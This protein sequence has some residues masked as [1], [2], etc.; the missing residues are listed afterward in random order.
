MF[1]NRI[2]LPIQL[3][4]PQFPE[5]R[6]SFRKANGTSKTMSVTIR[7]TYQLETDWFPENWHQRLKIALAH[8]EV[9]IEGEKY[10]GDISQDG[11]YNIEWQDTPLH[12][13]T[14]KGAVLVQVTPFNATNSNCQS[15]DEATQLSLED[16]T[17]TGIYGA[18][19]EDTDYTWPLADNDNI[20]CYPAVFS[21]TYF[22]SDYLDSASINA[23]TGELSFHTRTGLTSANGII[24]ATYRVTCPNGGYDEA[25]VY[26]DFSGSVEGCLAPTD[27]AVLDTGTDS[28]SFDW[29]DPDPAPDSYEWELYEGT[30]PVG[31]PVATGSGAGSASGT[32]GSLTPNTQY[33]F[34]VRSVCDATTSNWI[35]ITAMTLAEDVGCGQYRLTYTPPELSGFAS[36]NYINCVPESAVAFVPPNGSTLIC[37]LENSPGDPVSIETGSPHISITYL[38]P[39]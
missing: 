35:S 18:L 29:E 23:L 9:T 15:C 39:C 32:I 16:D 27:L 19:Q 33:Y 12:Y 7:K 37:A 11:D 34:Q 6:Q 1:K 5:E 26:A 21:L 30:G 20:C 24:I 4:S 14:A 36:V 22:N 3:H 10:L 25:N 38:G 2:R 8:D 17:V 31:S 13:P 28:L